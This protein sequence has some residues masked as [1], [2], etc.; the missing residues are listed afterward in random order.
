MVTPLIVDR[1]EALTL[2][3]GNMVAWTTDFGVTAPSAPASPLAVP[4]NTWVPVGAIDTTGLTE[5]FTS[6][7]VNVMAIGILSPFR[8]LYTDQTKTFQAVMLETE[9][10]ICQSVMFNTSLASL[11]RVP[12]S[13]P[14]LTS[15]TASGTGGTLA[16]ATYYY[17]IT[18]TNGVGETTAS[19]EVN[20]T[21]T[22]STSS[23]SLAFPALPTGVTGIKVYRGTATGA[24]N[25]LVATISSPTSPYVDTGGAT[26]AGSPPS[27]STAGVRTVVETS[28]P[29][30]DRRA[31]LFR[32]ADGGV[33][34]QFYI[35]QGEVTTRANVTY[36]QNAI[37][38]FDVTLTTYPDASGNTCYRTDNSPATPL[39]SNS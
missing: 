8:V 34:Q 21:T 28:N 3:A 25:V 39:Q 4:A 12:S 30:P 33:V 22:G 13:A 16:A 18:G 36:P 32:L 38:M 23:V 7:T 37:A 26:T 15:A 19:N 20:A 27:V 6:T 11:A 31:W 1:D 10:D 14:T 5:A 2:N 24:E 29:I 17:K 9:R 35:P